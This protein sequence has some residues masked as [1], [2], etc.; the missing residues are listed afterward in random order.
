MSNREVKFR[1]WV[2]KY[3]SA[4]LP[5]SQEPYMAIQGEPDIETLQSFMFHYGDQK[6]LMQWT[7]LKD[8][9]GKEIWESDIV[10]CQYGF[11]VVVFNAGCFMVE[12][13]DDPDAE[14]ELLA[15][16][17]NPNRGRAGKDRFEIIGNVHEHPQIIKA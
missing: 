1:V 10:K 9:N 6:N 13:K 7:G 15:F 16:L 2:D 11:G 12:W 14:M 8:K 17:P 4:E 5:F 3:Q